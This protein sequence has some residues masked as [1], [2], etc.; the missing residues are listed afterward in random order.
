ML[1]CQLNI[2]VDGPA[3]AGKSSV[4]R[5]V[6]EALGLSY[7]DTG[8]MYRALTW[9]ALQR[10]VSQHDALALAELAEKTTWEFVS[11]G[12]GANL[13]MDG[14]PLPSAIRSDT[15]TSLVS[16]VSSHEAVR[17]SMVTKQRNLCERGGFIADGRDIGTVVMPRAELKIF[18][19]AT[20]LERAERRRIEQGKPLD[21]LPFLLQTIERRDHLDS[22]REHS[23]LRI[24]EGSWLLDT[25]GMQFMQVVYCI[26]QKAYS[27]CT[28][29]V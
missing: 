5:A 28:E 9:K 29:G 11:T 12:E 27:V 21:E 18:L 13:W 1:P 7:L 23:P 14:G 24:A 2:A 22:T 20:A 10:Q 17:A 3:G 16:L 26:V 6:A 4:S 15:V 19:T 25:T 8:S